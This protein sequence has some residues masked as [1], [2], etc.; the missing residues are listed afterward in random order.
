MSEMI[1]RIARRFWDL[2]T[3]TYRESVG[4]FEIAREFLQEWA[5]AAIEEMREPTEA[6]LDAAINEVGYQG[7]QHAGTT[8]R[9]M[10][11]TAKK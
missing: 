7:G 4:S 11:D 2:S 8:W 9:A 6:M 10:I 1:D 3:P 5:V